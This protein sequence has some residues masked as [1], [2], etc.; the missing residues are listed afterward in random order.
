MAHENATT[1]ELAVLYVLVE[2]LGGHS[3]TMVSREKGRRLGFSMGRSRTVAVPDVVSAAA[4]TLRAENERLRAA[5]ERAQYALT[6]SSFSEAEA[7][8][9]AKR[10]VRAALSESAS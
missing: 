10:I 8:S 4:N 7:L 3:V 9:E 2:Q 6:K 1:A 5:L